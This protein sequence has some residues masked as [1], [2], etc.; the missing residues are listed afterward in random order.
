[1][2]DD[3]D[4]SRPPGQS[5]RPGKA[6]LIFTALVVS[7]GTVFLL[8]I[9]VSWTIGSGVRSISAEALQHHPGDRVPAL[10]AYVESDE[11][12]LADRNRAVWALGQLG[13]PGA[14]PVLQ[15]HWTGRP[16]DHEHELCQKE[17]E[18]AITL[19][20][21]GKNVTAIFWRGRL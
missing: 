17:L 19:C 20:R 3:A 5:V 1:M 21:G 13:D 14:L 18:K 11:H 8:T 7:A 12:S 15:K 9:T 4:G 6:L 16:C 10:M 2:I